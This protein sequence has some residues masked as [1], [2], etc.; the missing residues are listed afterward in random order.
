MQTI[1]NVAIKQY[2]DAVIANHPE[3][4]L[5]LPKIA[6][7]PKGFRRM[8]SSYAWGPFR[9]KVV[10]NHIVEDFTGFFYQNA[11]VNTTYDAIKL[12]DRTWITQFYKK[13]RTVYN[14]FV[15]TGNITGNVF[16]A[17]IN[18]IN[19]FMFI[20]GMYDNRNVA[21]RNPGLYESL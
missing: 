19:P 13:Y 20:K 16:F 3:Y 2:M 14:P 5:T 21:K 6:E 8:G 11:L 1:Q 15:Q 9:N 4:V 10:A 12:M 17:T 18:G 7:I